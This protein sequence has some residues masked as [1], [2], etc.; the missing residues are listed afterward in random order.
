MIGDP[1]RAAEWLADVL[2]RE[3]AALA[4]VDHAGAVALL[5]EKRAAAAAWMTLAEAGDSVPDALL[6]RLQA[7][8]AE[9]K[10]QLE[11]ALRVQSRVIGIVAGAVR[12][13]APR[14]PRYGATGTMAADRVGPIALSARA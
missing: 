7:L 12:S 4:A 3:N 1:T 9:N 8:G 10:R 2:A 11:Q 14:M 13:V 6:R 5:A